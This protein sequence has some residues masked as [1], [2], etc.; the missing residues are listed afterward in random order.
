MLNRSKTFILFPGMLLISLASATFLL[1]Q[2]N[3]PFKIMELDQISAYKED[4]IAY[5]HVQRNTIPEVDNSVATLLVVRD[6]KMYLIKDGFDSAKDISQNK[7]I[8]D[9]QNKLIPDL[10][11]NKIDNIPEYI[12]ITD[13]RI[14]ILQKDD[15]DFVN[16]NYGTFYRNVRNEFLKKHAEILRRLM[17]TR[18]DN[19]VFIER[20]ALPKPI[21]VGAPDIPTKYST[22]IV[23]KTDDEK[24]YIAEDA[25]GDGI[26]ENFSVSVPDGFNW[27]Y[28]S[29]PNIIFISIENYNDKHKDVMEKNKEVIDIIG[30]LADEAYRG[31]PE[32]ENAIQSDIKK[33]FRDKE[34]AID[35]S[36][37][38]DIRRWLDELIPDMGNAPVKEEKTK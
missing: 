9:S 38:K 5:Q 17:F 8:F 15:K 27:G 22:R 28:R 29:G 13:R 31:T 36:N 24:I 32:E 1:S 21:Y 20:K 11:V 10:W 19:G 26:T 6:N 34:K 35:F 4:R 2:D 18:S 12:R 14:I 7:L 25:D 3:V 33:N 23:A 16:K 30:K 37:P